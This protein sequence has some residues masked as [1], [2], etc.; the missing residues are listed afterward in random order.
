MRQVPSNPS[1]KPFQG[2]IK[3]PPKGKLTRSVKMGL[4]KFKIPLDQGEFSLALPPG[5]N[6]VAAGPHVGEATL[7]VKLPEHYPPDRYEVRSFRVVPVLIPV[8]E[9]G[10]LHLAY[11]RIAGQVWSVWEII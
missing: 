6:V 2:A 5:A 7:F 10:L 9:N 1:N 11:F 4:T 8:D 3:K